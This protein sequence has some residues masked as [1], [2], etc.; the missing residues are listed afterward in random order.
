M[1]MHEELLSRP[2]LPHWYADVLS[3]IDY[4]A[5]HPADAKEQQK[6]I[7]KIQSLFGFE[8]SALV[9]E[10]LAKRAVGKGSGPAAPP[11]APVVPSPGMRASSPI[12]PSAVASPIPKP[13]LPPPEAKPT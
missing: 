1:T 12:A 8:A 11:I 4:L 2:Q 9:K 3:V 5:D 13:K 7:G 10:E 6:A